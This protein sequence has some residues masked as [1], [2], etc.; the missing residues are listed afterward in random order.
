LLIEDAYARIVG[1][2]LY[3]SGLALSGLALS[4]LAVA[5]HPRFWHAPFHDIGESDRFRH[6]FGPCGPVP[7]EKRFLIS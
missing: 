5:F 2:A 7:A 6:A 3:L 4:G 1:L